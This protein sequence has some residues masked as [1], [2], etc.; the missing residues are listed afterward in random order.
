MIHPNR[1]SIRLRGYDYAQ[2]GMYFVTICTQQRLPLFGVVTDGVMQCNDA[3]KMV[4]DQWYEM[5]YKFSHIA[6]HEFVI[7]PNHI[8]GI[9]EITNISP[10]RA[11]F[12]A[13]VDVV[14]P[15]ETEINYPQGANNQGLTNSGLINQPPTLGQMMRAFKA[16]STYLY[17]KTNQTQGGQLWQRNYYEHIIRNQTAYNN[18]AN[19]IVNNPAQWDKDRFFQ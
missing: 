5:A 8:H 6:L 17:N 2:Q 19:Y 15:V 13:P 4:A 10:V 14:S 18:I 7:M 12:I 3:G 9:I 16:K 1:Q 11:R